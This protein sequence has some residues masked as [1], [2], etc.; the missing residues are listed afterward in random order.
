MLSATKCSSQSPGTPSRS[1]VV[2][3]TWRHTYPN[4]DV[5]IVFERALTLLLEH[6]ERTKLAQ[7]SR[8]LR[9]RGATAGSRHVPAAVRRAVWTRDNGQCAFVGTR[10]RCTE[11]GLPEFHH[12]VP[13]AEG[14]T[15][16]AE[17]I[18]LRCRAHNQLNQSNGSALGTQRPCGSAPGAPT[19]LITRAG[20]S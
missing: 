3:R 13:F 10:G 9:Q 8:P 16:T 1:C 14:G 4:G 19:G 20:P 15:A 5:G 12:V 7:V 2:S 11:R 6:L 18:Q 17:N